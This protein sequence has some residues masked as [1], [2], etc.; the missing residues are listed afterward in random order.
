MDED[1][2]DTQ[3]GVDSSFKRSLHRVTDDDKSE[4]RIDINRC[5]RVG[6]PVHSL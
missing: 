6:V 4:R 3:P 5:N 2:D 1:L